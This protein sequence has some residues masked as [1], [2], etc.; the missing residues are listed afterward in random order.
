MVH[1]FFCQF[2]LQRKMKSTLV[3]DL[4]QSQFHVTQFF[5]SQKMRIRRGPSVRK[6]CYSKVSKNNVGIKDIQ[7]I[8][9][10]DAWLFYTLEYLKKLLKEKTWSNIRFWFLGRSHRRTLLER[11]CQGLKGLPRIICHGSKI[12]MN[13]AQC[14]LDLEQIFRL[15]CS[16]P[17]KQERLFLVISGFVY[18]ILGWNHLY[19]R[20]YFSLHHNK[21][22]MVL[23]YRANRN[24]RSL[25][26]AFF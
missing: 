19:I 11:L 12:M 13:I 22:S 21:H 5:P 15:N 1:T 10:F 8:R 26:P 9:R 4:L 14:T 20:D 6:N 17:V 18:F 3:G 25:A 23:R 2:L 24:A 7:K 16:D